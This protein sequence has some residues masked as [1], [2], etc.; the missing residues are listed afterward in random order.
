MNLAGSN[1]VTSFEQTVEKSIKY[2][3]ITETVK[4]RTHIVSHTI[5]HM[6]FDTHHVPANGAEASMYNGQHHSIR[7]TCVLYQHK[8]QTPHTQSPPDHQRNQAAPHTGHLKQ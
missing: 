2:V 7:G 1:K 8:A 4:S 6:Y 5:L 3:R